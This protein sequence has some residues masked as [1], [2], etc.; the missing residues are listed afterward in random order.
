M[1]CFIDAHRRRALSWMEKEE[2]GIGE[3]GGRMGERDW[4]GRI[5]GDPV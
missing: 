2:E 1:A 3:V 5:G 4:E